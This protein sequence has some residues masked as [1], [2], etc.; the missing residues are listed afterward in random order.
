MDIENELNEE[1]EGDDDE[2]Y[3]QKELEIALYSQIHFEPNTDSFTHDFSDLP[4]NITVEGN[5]RSGF[6]SS[7]TTS[8]MML[9]EMLKEKYADDQ[10]WD[11]RIKKV[12]SDRN[13]TSE[14]VC[15]K[16]KQE[17]VVQKTGIEK[18]LTTKHKSII[19]KNA[20]QKQDKLDSEISLAEKLILGH[21]SVSDSD[22]N[23]TINASDDDDDDDGDEDT[24]YRRE[25]ARLKNENKIKKTV[26]SDG[27]DDR[28]SENSSRVE[29]LRLGHSSESESYINITISDDDDNYNDNDIGY[30]KETA[31]FI[32]KDKLIELSTDDDSN[33]T[34][35]K[36]SCPVEELIHELSSG[37]DCDTNFTISDDDDDA[38]VEYIKE[39]AWLKD[40]DEFMEALTEDSEN[41]ESDDLNLED[42][43]TEKSYIQSNVVGGRLL[44]SGTS[45]SDGLCFTY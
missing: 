15:D 4:Y 16:I 8:D 36:T 39:N 41:D 17:V 31:R 10:Q 35:R 19:L 12:H 2:F 14:H 1:S 24:G 7:K 30:R 34:V 25:S 42:G 27:N 33:G 18:K 13:R 6:L 37:S 44:I 3:H 32:D 28:N 45:E 38:D 43:L 21:S 22:D 29:K 11:S 23:I 20:R 40:E 5:D 26:S 9:H